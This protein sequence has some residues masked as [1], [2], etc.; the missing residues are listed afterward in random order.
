MVV[1]LIAPGALGVVIVVV[2]AILVGFDDFCLDLVGRDAVLLYR[3]LALVFLVGV[4][5]NI[6]N[7]AAIFEHVVGATTDDNARAFVGDVTDNIASR[8][9]E[10]VGERQLRG[11]YIRTGA[12]T[13][14]RKI[15]QKLILDFLLGV[16]DKTDSKPALFR[17]HFYDLAVVECDAEFFRDFSADDFAA[18]SVFAA[19]RNDNFLVHNISPLARGRLRCT[20]GNFQ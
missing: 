5:E 15:V 14:E 11:T 2:C 20:V 13:T 3:S 1:R 19:D 6:D 9:K 10:F 12:I 8:D 16:F 7:I 17:G 4:D 18:A